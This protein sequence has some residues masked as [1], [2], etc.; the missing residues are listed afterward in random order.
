GVAKADVQRAAFVVT[1]LVEKDSAAQIAADGRFGQ[2]QVGGIGVRAVAHARRVAGNQWRR[3]Q[4]WKDEIAEVLVADL[5][6][7]QDLRGLVEGARVVEL[8]VLLG[9]VVR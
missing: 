9:G 6:L 3:Y 2:L 5:R 7:L 8:L 1:R 4:R